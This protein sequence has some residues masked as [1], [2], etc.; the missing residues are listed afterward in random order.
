MY[1]P[2][3]RCSKFEDVNTWVENKKPVLP[4]Y[5]LPHNCLILS[6]EGIS[7][8]IWNIAVRLRRIYDNA[9]HAVYDITGTMCSQY[10]CICK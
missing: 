2:S 1:Y 9:L 6:L 7:C 3:K 4:D 8:H 5:F 10:S